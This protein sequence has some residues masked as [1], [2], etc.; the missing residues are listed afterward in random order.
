MKLKTLFKDLEVQF[1]GSKE[2]A[3]TGIASDSRRVSMGNLF[4]A[5]KGDTYDGNQFLKDA[6][7]NG[8]SAIL[9][10]ILDPFL[11]KV[12]QIIHPDP[13]FI[14]AS[15]AAKF[16]EYP[17]LDLEVIGVTGTSGKTT[18]TYLIRHILKNCGLIGGV[19][20]LI[21]NTRYDSTHTTPDAIAV[22]K[23]LREMKV[24]G[25]SSAVME[26]TSHAL[27]QR[28]VA[29]TRFSFAIFTNLTPEHL[30]YHK[31]MES[32]KRAKQKLFLMLDQDACAIVNADDPYAE[33]MLKVTTCEKMT[34]GI[35]RQADVMAKNI[36]LH[37]NGMTFD[38]EYQNEKLQFSSTLIGRFNV[39]NI[40]GAVAFGLKKGMTLKE[41]KAKIVSFQTVPGRLQRVPTEIKTVFVDYAH[42]PDALLKVLKTLRE[43]SQKKMITIFGCGGNRDRLKRPMMAKIAEEYSDIVIVTSDNPRNEEPEAIVSEIIQGFQKKGYLVEL[44]RKLAIQKALTLADKEDIV[45]I[46]GKGHEKMQIFAHKTIPFDDVQIAKELCS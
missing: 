44:D 22:Q 25:C 24:H 8:A 37:A 29:N 45:L 23:M 1:H 5:R 4:I 19:E 41:L 2:T 15:L 43:I 18:T 14:E 21:G 7:Q 33:D 20:C 34:F 10:D 13:A 46:A 12:T 28:R 35:E 38:V 6:V 31:D 30:D 42:K 16:Y 17:S 27:E 3:I 11:G 32:Y 36:A 39:S 9:T 40:L 26:V